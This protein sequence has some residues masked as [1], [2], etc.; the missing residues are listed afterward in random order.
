MRRIDLSGKTIGYWAVISFSH[1]AGTI[2]AYW[3]C[4]C[5]CGNKRVVSRRT[6]LRGTSKSCGCRGKDWCRTHGLE[7]TKVYNA[8]A[9]IIQRCENPK[10]HSFARYGGRGIKVCP[11]WR[12]SFEAFYAD[13]G[14]C[15]N[16]RWSVGRIN[17]DGDYSPENCRWESPTQ[18]IRNRGI[19]KIIEFRG[20][21]KSLAEWAEIVGI[22]RR[23]I[24]DRLRSGWSAD[25][26]LTTRSRK[27]TIP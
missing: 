7:G 20:E 11:Q 10:Y 27:G 19:T 3:N 24:A 4:I 6:L 13:M 17:N 22:K 8:W 9:G 23:I 16:S 18:Q 12:D 25:R 2:G 5:E 14:E 15:P 26:A 21:A 1:S